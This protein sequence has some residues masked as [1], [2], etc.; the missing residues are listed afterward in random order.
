MARGPPADSVIDKLY[1]VDGQQR[2]ITLCLI[3]AA[4]KCR[5]EAQLER[6][7]L[8]ADQRKTIV[9]L[10]L[11]VAKMLWDEGEVRLDR[12]PRPRMELKRRDSDFF[13]ELLQDP[14][15]FVRQEY[16]GEVLK[17]NTQRSIWENLQVRDAPSGLFVQSIC[18]IEIPRGSCVNLFNV[19]GRVEVSSKVS[20]QYA[21]LVCRGVHD[22]RVS[23]IN[24]LDS[25]ACRFMQ[26]F[27]ER[28]RTLFARFQ[29]FTITSLLC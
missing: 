9:S 8:A 24:V 2:L 28:S 19:T 3:L 7:D 20:V 6:D 22:G 29:V 18:F 4:L 14:G 23:I 16:D 11:S 10:V 17:G 15:R 1:L 25:K 5:L 21:H 13:N 26:S 27:D 12:G